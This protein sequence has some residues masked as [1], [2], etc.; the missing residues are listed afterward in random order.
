ML[1]ERYES[2]DTAHVNRWLV[3]HLPDAPADAL[4]I[5]AG[6]GRDPAWLGGRGS[7]KPDVTFTPLVFAR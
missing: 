3:P 2:Y 5:G 4:D 7:Q 1:L 6:T